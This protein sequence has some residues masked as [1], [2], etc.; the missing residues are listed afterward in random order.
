MISGV[1][2][3]SRRL[4]VSVVLALLILVLIVAWLR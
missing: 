3:R 1:D 4:I 2:P